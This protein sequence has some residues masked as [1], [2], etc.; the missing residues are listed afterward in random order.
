MFSLTLHLIP[1]NSFRV[2]LQLVLNPMFRCLTVLYSVD[3]WPTTTRHVPGSQPHFSLIPDPEQNKEDTTII[4]VVD[5]GVYI[6]L[7][8][9]IQF[10][11]L[12]NQNFEKKYPRSCTSCGTLDPGFERVFADLHGVQIISSK[13]FPIIENIT[14]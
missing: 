12:P 2:I 7:S 9:P 1:S 14:T 13:N 11:H 6:P 8:R 3:K 5:Y 4:S 10:F